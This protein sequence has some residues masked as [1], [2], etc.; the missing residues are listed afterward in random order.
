MGRKRQRRQCRPFSCLKYGTSLL[1][2]L[3]RNVFTPKICLSHDFVFPPNMQVPPVFFAFSLFSSQYMFV[4]PHISLSVDS[5]LPSLPLHRIFAV[6][7]AHRPHPTIE[8]HRV[9]VTISDFHSIFHFHVTPSFIANNRAS[10][11][12]IFAV[13]A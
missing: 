12:A 10:K 3:C 1:K 13:A 8:L 4:Y 2:Q 7:F 11:H 6:C 5:S 9:S